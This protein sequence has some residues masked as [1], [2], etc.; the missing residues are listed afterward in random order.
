MKR[1]ETTD[2]PCTCDLGPA[3]AKETVFEKLQKPDP[4]DG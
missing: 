2:L 1:H 3:P 4:F